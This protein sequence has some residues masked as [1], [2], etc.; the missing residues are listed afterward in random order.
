M[1]HHKPV[2]GLTGGIGSG[3]TLV[4]SIM[5]ELGCVSI[6]ADR[7]AREI[8]ECG[9]GKKFAEKEFGKDVIGPEG[10]IDRAKI[11]DIVFNDI[12]KKKALEG[13]IHPRVISRQDEL[14]AQYQKNSSFKAIVIDVP[15]LI[16]TGLQKICDYV[17]FVDCDFVIRKNR[18]IQYRRWSEDELARREKFLF[19]IYL[20]RSIADAIVNNSFT[21]DRC[22]GQVEQILSRIIPSENLKQTKGSEL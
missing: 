16:E 14:I 9:E 5:S 19:S 1:R 4:A 20:K 8:L 22:R 17:I 15:L 6:N 11:A 3:K 13:Y 2:I 10:N 21:I 7:L 12:R 18:V